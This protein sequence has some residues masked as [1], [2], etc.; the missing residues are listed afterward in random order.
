MSQ[1]LGESRL[2]AR[3]LTRRFGALPAAI[4]EKLA[5]ATEA[6]LEAWSDAVLSAESLEAVFRTTQH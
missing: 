2:L 1:W 6:D 4:E 5:K 3:L